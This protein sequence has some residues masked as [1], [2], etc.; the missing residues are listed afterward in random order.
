MYI[1]L[2]FSRTVEQSFWEIAQFFPVTFHVTN[3]HDLLLRK[4]LAI[5]VITARVLVFCQFYSR[6]NC[7]IKLGRSASLLDFCW[8]L[9]SQWYCPGH[10]TSSDFFE[11]YISILVNQFWAALSFWFTKYEL[12]KPFDKCP[13]FIVTHNCS[14]LDRQR[15]VV[16]RCR[17]KNIMVNK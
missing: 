4:L 14:S 9:L 11:Q 3:F 2:N 17:A 10:T 16:R 8:S 15:C 7:V 6:V 5:S 13:W 1:A 12:K